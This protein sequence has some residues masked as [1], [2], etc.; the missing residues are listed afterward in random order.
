MELTSLNRP[1][2]FCKP[3]LRCVCAQNKMER[4]MQAVC[5]AQICNYYHDLDLRRMELTIVKHHWISFTFYNVDALDDYPNMPIQ[6]NPQ[7]PH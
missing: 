3:H 5:L 2:F 1:R 7:V 4:I 6:V